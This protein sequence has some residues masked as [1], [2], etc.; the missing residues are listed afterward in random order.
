VLLHYLS[1]K[2]ATTVNDLTASQLNDLSVG[3]VSALIIIHQIVVHFQ[4][5]L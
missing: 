5:Q 1:N 4:S 2:Q 3:Q